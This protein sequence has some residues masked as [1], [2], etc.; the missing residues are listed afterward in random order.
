[1]QRNTYNYR[2]LNR[3]HNFAMNKV[4]RRAA[5]CAL[6]IRF[7][8]EQC[9]FDYRIRARGPVKLPKFLAFYSTQAFSM[10]ITSLLR[11]RG[12]FH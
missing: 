9:I 10:T 11:D 3:N 7:C 5:N 8:I 1:M 2:I 12:L 4:S 6:Q